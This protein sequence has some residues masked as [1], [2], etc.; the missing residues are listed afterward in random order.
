[1]NVLLKDV[2]AMIN[3]QQLSISLGLVAVMNLPSGAFLFRTQLQD[4]NTKEMYPTD[5]IY[6]LIFAFT[7]TDPINS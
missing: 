1:M 6:S 5:Q 7:H 4:L 3:T 2:F